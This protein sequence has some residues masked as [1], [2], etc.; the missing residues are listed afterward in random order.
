M[1]RS[2][3]EAVALALLVLGT[4]HVRATVVVPAELGEL[5][6]TAR[7][8][9]HGR[10]VDVHPQVSDDRRHVDT[11]VTLQVAT[12]LKGDLGPSVTFRVPGGQIGRYRTVV[13]DA[14]TFS[15]GEEV[16]LLF[17]SRGP[18][19]PYVLGLNQGVFRVVLDPVTAAR[20]IVPA[21]L[22]GEG[23][24]W[25][26]VVRGDPGHAPLLLTDFARQVQQIVA[27]H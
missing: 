23:A 17:G 15:P 21:P 7:A 4:A 9:A 19:F 24:E 25:T 16:V 2:R 13:L 1:P 3:R 18:S 14:P 22:L 10:I 8:I 12:Y 11:L 27:A 5:V 6:L 26:R 20:R